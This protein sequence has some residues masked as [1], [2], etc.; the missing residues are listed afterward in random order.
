MRAHY[1]QD[2]AGVTTGA[3]ATPQQSCFPTMTADNRKCR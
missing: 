1:R 3:T 2:P